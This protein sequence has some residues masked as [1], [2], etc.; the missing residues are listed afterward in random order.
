VS[1][2]VGQVWEDTY[3]CDAKR[4]WNRWLVKV[5]KLNAKSA[6]VEPCEDNGWFTTTGYEWQ[7]R[8]EFKHF[9]NGRMVLVKDDGA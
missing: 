4:P 8:M 3:L 7:Y 5:M 1:V 6:R 9:E 2:R